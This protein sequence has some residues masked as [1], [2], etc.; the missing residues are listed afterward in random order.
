MP[1]SSF[2]DAEEADEK[3]TVFLSHPSVVTAMPAHDSGMRIIIN[4]I[5]K[6][7]PAFDR[8]GQNTQARITS[9]PFCNFLPIPTLYL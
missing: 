9:R 3:K 8:G 7:P 5:V 4:Q 6:E 1:D 2:L